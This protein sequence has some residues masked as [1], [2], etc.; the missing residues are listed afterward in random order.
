MTY[1]DAAL[2]GPQLCST[3]V[4]WLSRPR[5]ARSAPGRAMTATAPPRKPASTSEGRLVP[6][7]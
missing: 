2:A 6:H 3:V 4:R 1:L 7:G 5:R